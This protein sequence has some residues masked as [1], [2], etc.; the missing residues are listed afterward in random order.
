MRL[1]ERLNRLEREAVSGEKKLKPLP[2]S[3]PDDATDEEMDK[4]RAATGCDVYRISE[5]WDLFI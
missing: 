5:L 3:V 1:N 4:I 2:R